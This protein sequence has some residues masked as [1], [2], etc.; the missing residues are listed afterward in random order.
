MS[1]YVVRKY[2]ILAI[3]YILICGALTALIFNHQR[4][5]NMHTKVSI[6][7]YENFSIEVLDPSNVVDSQQSN[8]LR[9]IYS[10]LV[11]FDTDG[12]IRSG[13]AEKFEVNNNTIRFYI[14]DNFKSS[15]GD[16]IT[17]KDI[18]LSFKRLLILDKNTHGKLTDFINCNLV[19]KSITSDCEGL[20]FEGQI[21]EMD[22]KEAKFIPF[23]LPIL[24]NPDFSILPEKAVNYSGDLKI[25][26]FK[27]TSGPYYLE[28][29]TKDKTVFHVNKKHYL[30]DDRNPETIELIPAGNS[31]IEKL[32]NGDFDIILT[33]QALYLRDIDLLG[34]LSNFNIHKTMP[35]K[36]F[37]VNFTPNGRKKLHREERLGIGAQLRNAFYNSFSGRRDFN[38]TNDYFSVVGDGA[39][40]PEQQKQITNAFNTFENKLTREIT[41]DISVTWAEK[42]KSIVEKIPYCKF[43]ELV[44][45]NNKLIEPSPDA[46]VI[47]TDSGGF[48]NTS[49]LSYMQSFGGLGM[50]DSEFSKWLSDYVDTKDTIERLKKFRDLHFNIL[51][52]AQV[53]PIGIEPYYGIARK[54]WKIE[55]YQMFA[56]SPFWT[57]KREQ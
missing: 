44:R 40:Q 52:N 12:R 46:Y 27:N 3:P 43:V 4:I 11:Y 53:I 57:I 14:R 7:T 22:L 51:Y 1:L 33:F 50:T 38:P 17:A 21:F 54:P 26:N 48:D 31:R 39:L 30:I 16:L 10:T 32:K 23:F 6:P 35:I 24:A 25:I 29:S 2:T 42:A 28:S 13:L 45:K 20:R 56:G 8:L 41:A 5:Y 18:Y 55:A 47:D 34:D 36:L 49:L 15:A 9:S 37:I 19:P